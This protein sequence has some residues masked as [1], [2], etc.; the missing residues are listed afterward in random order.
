VKTR[1]ISAIVYRVYF[2]SMYKDPLEKNGPAACTVLAD[3]AEQALS[4]VKEQFP[5]EIVNAIHCDRSFSSG[6][7]RPEIIIL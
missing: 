4:K 2:E 6:P 3:N 1:K 5:G 7:V